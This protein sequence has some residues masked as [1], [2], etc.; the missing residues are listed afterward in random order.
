MSDGVCKKIKA[1]IS[2]FEKKGYRVDFIYLKDGKIVFREDGIENIIGKVGIIKKT[3]AYIR[4]YNI[5]KKKKY[6][7][8]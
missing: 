4:M 2:V 1:Q 8:V 7:W 6:D 5:L 3:P